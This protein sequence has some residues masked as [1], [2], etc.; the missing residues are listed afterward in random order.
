MNMKNLKNKN[1][2][3]IIIL[4]ISSLNACKDNEILPNS[5]LPAN[6]KNQGT[7]EVKSKNLEITFWD[8]SA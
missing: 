7:I 8:W 6:Y 5:T 4:I 1:K 2:L 3:L